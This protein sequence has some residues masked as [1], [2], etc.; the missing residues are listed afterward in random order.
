MPEQLLLF[1]SPKSDV[2]ELN[3]GMCMVIEKLDRYRKSM[4]AKLS[5]L[6]AQ[7]RTL[8]CRVSLLEMQLYVL[9]GYIDKYMDIKEENNDK[10]TAQQDSQ[11][12]TIDGMSHC[13]FTHSDKSL[14]G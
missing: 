14:F 5:T 13:E 8:E 3:D 11:Y 6:S 7:V 1:H 12:C 10:D 4:H 9:K 2:E